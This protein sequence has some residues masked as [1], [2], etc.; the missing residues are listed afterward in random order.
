MLR[1][2]LLERAVAAQPALVEE[3]GFTAA[4]RATRSGERIAVGTRA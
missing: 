2:Q 4:I 3:A 1:A